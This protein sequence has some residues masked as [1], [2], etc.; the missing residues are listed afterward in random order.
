MG[1]EPETERKAVQCI[2]GHIAAAADGQMPVATVQ[3]YV[4]S[5]L[6]I[7]FR[8]PP[9]FRIQDTL[10]D[11]IQSSTVWR[12]ENPFILRDLLRVE[13]QL[14]GGEPRHW[15]DRTTARVV[16]NFFT[17]L[18][19]ILG[20]PGFRP[21]KHALDPRFITSDVLGVAQAIYQDRAFG[22]MPI[23]ADAFMDAGCEDE[24]IIGHLRQPIKEGILH[25]RGCW[26]VE[27]AL[28]RA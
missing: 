25:V 14:K 6:H 26:A 2:S 5:E 15:G 1:G 28:G 16:T 27:M 7:L 13:S 18:H 8:G 19:E 17:S 21:K 3:E 12:A 24:Q 22:R 9:R 4:N 20:P 10:R 11:A 23:L